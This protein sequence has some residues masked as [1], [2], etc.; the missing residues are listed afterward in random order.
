M[1]V[2]LRNAQ[3]GL[4]TITVLFDLS[5]SARRCKIRILFVVELLG[6][7]FGPMRAELHDICSSPKVNGVIKTRMMVWVG[8]VTQSGS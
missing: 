2:P 4:K 8:H 6:R 5:F 7:I 3:K 1:A